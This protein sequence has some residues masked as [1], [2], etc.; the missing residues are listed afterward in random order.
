MG[1]I[2]CLIADSAAQPG[3]GSFGQKN[4]ETIVARNE[5][6]QRLNDAK[7]KDESLRAQ[8]A[9]RGIDA[10]RALFADPAQ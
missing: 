1:Q 3:S 10:W 6:F 4:K 2:G 9:Y 5:L 8:D 7:M